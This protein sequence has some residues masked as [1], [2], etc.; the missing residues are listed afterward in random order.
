[1]KNEPFNLFLFFKEDVK[2]E[3]H[4]FTMQ[5]FVDDC[6]VVQVER[7][8]TRTEYD[9][10]CVDMLKMMLTLSKTVLTLKTMLTFW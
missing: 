2:L 10:T 6:K 3:R 8:G 7:V 4:K 1:M 5:K 9:I